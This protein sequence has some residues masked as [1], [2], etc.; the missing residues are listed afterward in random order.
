MVPKW[1]T[2]RKPFSVTP[3]ALLLPGDKERAPDAAHGRAEGLA[4]GYDRVKMIRSTTG[5]VEVIGTDGVPGQ[6]SGLKIASGSKWCSLSRLRGGYADT[7][8]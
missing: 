4:R 2:L 5:R 6:H 7:H 3:S 8:V 1:P